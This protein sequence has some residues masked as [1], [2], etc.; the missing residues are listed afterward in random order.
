[1]P[2]EWAEVDC[3]LQ[4]P[5]LAAAGGIVALLLRGMPLRI[6]VGAGFITLFGI[7]GLNGVALIVGSLLPM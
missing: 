4:N 1:M 2:M 7:A 5:P 6:S 3:S